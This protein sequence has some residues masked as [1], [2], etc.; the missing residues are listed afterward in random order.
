MKE[1]LKEKELESRIIELERKTKTDW[2][3]LIWKV[4][5]TVNIFILAYRI[6]TLYGFLSTT[7]RS[8]TRAWEAIGRANI[9]FDEHLEFMIEVIEAL[10][11][12]S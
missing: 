2:L 10:S 8:L 4:A 1:F 12:M 7:I 3:D 5:L 9:R 6:H 11:K